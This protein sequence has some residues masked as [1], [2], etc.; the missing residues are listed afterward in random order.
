MKKA[1]T[2]A[3]KKSRFAAFEVEVLARWS[4]LQRRI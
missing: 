3:T 4:V 1:T 2:K